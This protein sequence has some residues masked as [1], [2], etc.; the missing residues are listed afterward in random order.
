MFGYSQNQKSTDQSTSSPSPTVSGTPNNNPKQSNPERLIDCLNEYKLF[1]QNTKVDERTCQFY[2]NGIP[3][4]VL[5]GNEYSKYITNVVEA[6]ELKSHAAIRNILYNHDSK[7][8]KN[9]EFIQTNITKLTNSSQ[10]ADLPQKLKER[11]EAIENSLQAIDEYSKDVAVI[12]SEKVSKPLTQADLWTIIPYIT[13]VLMTPVAI[14]TIV[15][16]VQQKGKIKALE[17]QLQKLNEEIN[18]SKNKLLETYS[19]I[20]KVDNQNISFPS[21]EF[22][23]LR[24]EVSEIKELVKKENPSDYTNKIVSEIATIIYEK[25]KLLIEEANNIQIEEIIRTLDLKIVNENL[26]TENERLKSEINIDKKSLKDLEDK[27]QKLVEA[28]EKDK[29]EIKLQKKQI[30]NLKDDVKT[31]EDDIEKLNSSSRNDEKT[32]PRLPPLKDHEEQRQAPANVVLP[33]KI[34]ELVEKYNQD[35]NLLWEYVKNNR[36]SEVSEPEEFYE[37]RRNDNSQP[38]IF[39]NL[40]SDT[41]ESDYRVITITIEEGDTYLLFPKINRINDVKY[42]RICGRNSLFECSGYTEYTTERFDIIQPATVSPR[43]ISQKEWQIKERG[44]LEFKKE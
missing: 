43:D 2:K 41:N 24:A 38:I 15:F 4:L 22:D 39:K 6:E 35:P 19:A 9:L 5:W 10:N 27:N 31:L 29:K 17:L 36:V 26:R 13:L 7:N 21:K 40:G 28:S 23:S 16:V 37:K 14:V 8:K 1:I 25:L 18:T 20:F 11:L 3:D 42:R 44:K 12:G 30:D 33:R 32:T 34:V